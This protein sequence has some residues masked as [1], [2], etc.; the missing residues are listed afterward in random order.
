[1]LAIIGVL[2]LLGLIVGAFLSLRSIQKKQPNKK[3]FL[4]TGAAFVL[5]VGALIFNPTSPEITISTSSVETNKEGVATITGKTNE[6]SK[7]TVDGEQ[8][9]TDNGQFSYNVTLTDN[10][11]KK[12]TFVASIGDKDKAETIDVKPSKAFIS[13]LNEEKQDHESLEKAKTALVLAEKKPTKKNYDEAATLITSL[14][15]AQDNLTERLTVVKENVPIYEAVEQAETTQTREQLDAAT[16]LVAKATL[17]KK[18]LNKRLA[19]VQ[20]KVLEKETAE[21]QLAEARS[22]V[23]QA[24]QNPTDTSYSQALAK[25]NNL[26]TASTEL[27]DR[28]NAIKQ[29]LTDQKAEAQRVAAAEEAKQATQTPAAN[30]PEVQQMVLVTPT[31]KKYHNRECTRGTYTSATLEEAQARG[32]TPCSKCY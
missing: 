9:K 26:P 19:T 3:F 5:T 15:L 12:V 2:S 11:S 29:T 8:I 32:L 20:E 24:E 14:T 23:E 10:Q 6:Q 1:M 4:L 16:V 30:N 17:N 22:A 13:Y 18:E 28:V 25:I 31:G 7:I 21:K 27:T